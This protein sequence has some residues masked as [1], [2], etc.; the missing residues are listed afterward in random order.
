MRALSIRQPWAHAVV[1][2]G[3]DIENRCWT[4]AYRGQLAIHA[5][6][7]CTASAYAEVREWI[8]RNAPSAKVPARADLQRGGLI[9]VVTLVDVRPPRKS[10][11]PYGPWHDGYSYAWILADPRE[12]PFSPLPGKLKIF[13]V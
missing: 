11:T 3:K 1:H 8:G 5:G 2:C 6:A 7:S 13:H 9:G 4:T 12:V 10:G